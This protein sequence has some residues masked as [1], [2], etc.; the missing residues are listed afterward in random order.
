MERFGAFQQSANHS[1]TYT[2]WANNSGGSDN[3]TIN[4][5][6]N[7]EAPDI[8]YSPDWFVLTNN[9]AM[10]P[11]ATPTNAGGA[12]PSLPGAVLRNQCQWFLG[13]D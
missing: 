11:T 5:T 6:I 9:T 2:V 13:D 7:D 10:S 3:A 1:V 12:I 8:S 4:I